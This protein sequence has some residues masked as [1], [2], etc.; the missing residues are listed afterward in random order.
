MN[1]CTS[2]DSIIELGSSEKEH[3]TVK[4][5]FERT[6]PIVKKTCKLEVFPV[7]ITSATFSAEAEEY[8]KTLSQSKKNK[9]LTDTL[10][11]FP[12][13]I[14]YDK[15][16]LNKLFNIQLYENLHI[17]SSPKQ[18][19]IINNKVIRKSIKTCSQLMAFLFAMERINGKEN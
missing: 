14:F 11:R 9:R 2:S 5:F 18:T 15:N 3:D 17:V 13:N 1:F 4:R 16:E 12:N 6:I 8:M 19:H 7:F 10:A